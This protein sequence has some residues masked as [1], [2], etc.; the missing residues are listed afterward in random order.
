M[1][2]SIPPKMAGDSSRSSFSEVVLAVQEQIEKFAVENQ[3]ESDRTV[4]PHLE[5]VAENCLRKTWRRQIRSLEREVSSLEKR[6]CLKK[7]IQTRRRNMTDD[8]PNDIEKLRRDIQSLENKLEINQSLTN[9]EVLKTNCHIVRR[10]IG[11]VS[12]NQ[13]VE[14]QCQDVIFKLDLTITESLE[15]ESLTQRVTELNVHV[16]VDTYRDLSSHI[17]EI[18]NNCCVHG[19]FRLIEPYS[20]CKQQRKQTFAYFSSTFPSLVSVDESDLGSFLLI[21]SKKIKAT[22]QLG[23]QGYPP[24]RE[25]MPPIG[26]TVKA[27]H[28]YESQGNPFHSSQG[29]QSARQSRPPYVRSLPSPTPAQQKVFIFDVKIASLTP[30]RQ[31]SVYLICQS[32]EAY[33]M[34]NYPVQ[35][36]LT[37]VYTFRSPS[38]TTVRHGSMYPM[39]SYQVK[40]PSDRRLISNDQLPSPTHARQGSM[41][42]MYSYP[43]HPRPTDV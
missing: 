21:Q 28:Q 24:A 36:P 33:L 31:T 7:Q 12:K 8:K 4:D 13:F 22:H 19:F 9:I 39:Y 10:G 43:V 11:G 37:G 2:E 30:N 14:G 32:T 25:P 34:H 40:P 20:N 17:D 42:P 3:I 35:P 27:T 15:D 18:V 5:K 38:R 6:I 23:S 29:H 16:E 26:T 1:I 41:Y